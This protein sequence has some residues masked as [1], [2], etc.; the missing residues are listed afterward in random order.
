[1]IALHNY[2][3]GAAAVAK[4]DIA[5]A[6]MSQGLPPTDIIP[7]TPTISRPSSAAARLWREKPWAMSVGSGGNLLTAV[8]G[9][10]EVDEMRLKAE[11]KVGKETGNC[12]LLRYYV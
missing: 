8:S 12:I 6:R 11:K 4:L 7:R 1:M 9:K 3:A 10:E 2:S 5:R